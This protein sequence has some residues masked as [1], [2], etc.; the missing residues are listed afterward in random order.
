M[1]C[2][3][4]RTMAE[5]Y[6]SSELPVDTS[7]QVNA[8][9]ERCAACRDEFDARAGI[10]R[11]VRAAFLADAAL[12]P[13]AAFAARLRARLDAGQR[14][15]RHWH[16]RGGALWA[17]AAGL[18]LVAALGWQWLVIERRAPGALAALV[19]DAAGD[20]RDCALQHAL[21]EAPISLDEAAR[22]YDPRYGTLRAAIDRSAPALDGSMSVVGAHWCVFRGRAFAHVVVRHRGEIVSILLTPEQLAASAEP[23]VPCP[24]S[25]GFTVSCFATPGHAAFVV[26][27]LPVSDSLDLARAVAPVL[28]AHFERG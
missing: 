11:S 22:R 4:A 8:H 2:A 24:S 10:R 7:H 9:L 20:H 15:A 6:L 26:S 23:A 18:M 12:A 16:P 25:D 5:S 13:D 14:P 1:T 21:E 3:Q 17:L 19:G 28:H 27:T